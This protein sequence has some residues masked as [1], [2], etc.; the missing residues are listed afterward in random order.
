VRTHAVTVLPPV[1]SSKVLRGKSTLADA[2]KPLIGFGDPVF[3]PPGLK[4][5]ARVAAARD[6]H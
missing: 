3:D 4:H 2:A 1:A 6:G 5:N